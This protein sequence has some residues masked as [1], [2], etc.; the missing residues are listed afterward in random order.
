MIAILTRLF[1][2][3]TDPNVCGL[4]NCQAE[5]TVL[6]CRHHIC[7]NCIEIQAMYSHT[8]PCFQC[9]GICWNASKSKLGKKET[10]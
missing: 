9:K 7:E 5:T 6:K 10:K 3:P 2:K 4:C 1:T 8:I